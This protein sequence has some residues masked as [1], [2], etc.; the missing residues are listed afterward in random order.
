MVSFTKV[1]EVKLPAQRRSRNEP[2]LY[3]GQHYREEP[4][5][6]FTINRACQGLTFSEG[7]PSEQL[8]CILV[9][10]HSTIHAL[11]NVQLD[12]VTA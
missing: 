5:S 10:H 8:I 7:S 12:I 9:E 3:R 4:S 11:N 2:N 1:Y 6:G